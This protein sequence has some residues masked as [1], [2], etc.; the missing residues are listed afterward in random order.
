MVKGL[1][2]RR[3]DGEFTLRFESAHLEQ[4]YTRIHE[5]TVITQPATVLPDQPIIL[6][7]VHS[8]ALSDLEIDSS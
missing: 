3:R 6:L 5:M 7:N 8:L 4:G 1:L 2:F